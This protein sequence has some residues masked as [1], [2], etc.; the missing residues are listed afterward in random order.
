MISGQSGDQHNSQLEKIIVPLSSAMKPIPKKLRDEMAAE[1]YYHHCCRRDEHCSGRVTWE[2]CFT[3]A[4][5]QV[6]ERWAIIPLCEYHHLGSGLN[7]RINREIAISRATPE[8]LA[9][10]P[11]IEKGYMKIGKILIIIAIVFSLFSSFSPAYATKIIADCDEKGN[12]KPVAKYEEEAGWTNIIIL[13]V[14]GA[15]VLSL[16]F[17]SMFLVSQQELAFIERFGKF[18][19]VSGAGLNFKVPFIDKRAGTLSLK[20]EELQNDITVKSSDNAFLVVPVRVQ[21]KVLAEFAKE[22]FY[23]LQNPGKQMSSYVLNVVRSTATS[24]SMDEIFKSKDKFE[25]EVKTEL[26]EKFSGFGFSIV[27]VLVDDPVPSDE[28]ARAFD[29]VISSAR[30]KEAAQNEADAVQIKMIGE[31]KA[32]ALSL[33]LKANAYVNQ[34]KI[35]TNGLNEMGI[36]SEDLLGFLERI[37]WRDAIRD[38]KNGSVVIIPADMNGSDIAKIKALQKS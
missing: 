19:K 31:A 38:I 28:V 21:F 20:I 34:R 1:Y 7:K 29:R 35:I 10:Y 22:A 13:S 15:F 23:T 33:E 30:V 8:D 3:Y 25:Q 9:K 32:E 12:C 5:R 17:G 16:L 26:N 24:M 14:G 36:K 4:G 37:D 11:G 2:H 27:N 6:Q 18:K